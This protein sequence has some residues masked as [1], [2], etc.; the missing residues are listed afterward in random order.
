[1]AKDKIITTFVFVPGKRFL[2]PY[3]GRVFEEETMIVDDKVSDGIPE[4]VKYAVMISDTDIYLVKSGEHITEDAP[5]D[6]DSEFFAAENTF[7]DWCN[8]RDIRYFI[9]RCANIVGTG[10]DGLPMRLARGIDRGLLCH[11]EGNEAR[12]SVVHAVDVAQAA[13][14]VSDRATEGVVFEKTV[15]NMTDG[16]ET[17]VDDLIDAL[18]FRMN[19]KK[20]FKM[21]RKLARLIYGKSYFDILTTTKTFDDSRAISV[22]E[23]MPLHK[24]TEYLRTHVYNDE[25][26]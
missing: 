20:V 22:T 15:A 3:L 13:R 26:L 8:S 18:A 16:T 17:P 2:A 19:D 10:M 7:V 1:M 23:G 5:V 25:S 11:I 14:I 4:T 24:V 12:I 9:L 6:T 21:G